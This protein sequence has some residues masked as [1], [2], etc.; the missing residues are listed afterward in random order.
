MIEFS[1]Q[2]A[3]PSCSPALQNAGLLLEVIQNEIKNSLSLSSASFVD[4]SMPEDERIIQ[5]VLQ[6]DINSFSKLVQ[7][8]QKRIASRLWKFTS[9]PSS[10]EEM[11]HDV[12]VDAYKSLSKFRGDGAFISWLLTIAT[13]R[14]YRFW[15]E[16]KR[17]TRNIELTENHAH[18]DSSQWEKLSADESAETLRELLSQLPPRDRLVLTLTYWE[19]CT[20]AETAEQV[21]WSLTM[22]KVQVHRAK[23]KLKN[24]I[25]TQA[26][27][28]IP[29]SEGENHHE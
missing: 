6:G 28:I 16:K 12:F 24:L 25:L 14:G 27:Q 7:M 29:G 2:F 8:Y 15:K 13:R 10:H 19:Q 26:R 18:T 23:K 9:D 1:K 20:M 22:V 21:G 5:S 17:R 11:V 4:E 3:L